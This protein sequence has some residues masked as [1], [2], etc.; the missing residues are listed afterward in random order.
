MSDTYSLYSCG[1]NT[2]LCFPREKML[3]LHWHVIETIAAVSIKIVQSRPWLIRQCDL[4][5]SGIWT[6]YFTLSLLKHA[7]LS[8]HKRH[9]GNGTFHRVWSW[10]LFVRPRAPLRWCTYNEQKSTSVSQK[11]CNLRPHQWLPGLPKSGYTVA[12]LANG[13]QMILILIC[14]VSIIHSWCFPCIFTAL[15]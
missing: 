15:S 9:R 5:C 7:L 1:Q 3:G 4:Y 8:P 10:V 12:S 13:F 11:T 14:G 6:M 2:H